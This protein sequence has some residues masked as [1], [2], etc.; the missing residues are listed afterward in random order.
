MLQQLF[1]YP[2]AKKLIG[3]IFMYDVLCELCHYEH[4]VH[5][6]IEESNTSVRKPQKC[7]G[8]P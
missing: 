2:C 3:F 7:G 5:F 1:S 8:F 4:P 6:S